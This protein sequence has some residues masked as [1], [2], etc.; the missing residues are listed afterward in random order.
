MSNTGSLDGKTRTVT[1]GLTKPMLVTPLQLATLLH[2]HSNS[3]VS[4]L[5]DKECINFNQ[6]S[7]Y[8][9]FLRKMFT[10][11]I[12]LARPEGYDGQNSLPMAMLGCGTRD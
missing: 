7:W 9:T 5:A 6:S 3:R 4:G 1:P 8:F 2:G 11:T 12:S 10:L